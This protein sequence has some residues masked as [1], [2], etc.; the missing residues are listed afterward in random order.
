MNYKKPQDEEIALGND[1]LAILQDDNVV[2]GD[3]ELAEIETHLKKLYAA[4]LIELYSGLSIRVEFERFVKRPLYVAAL[5]FCKG[6]KEKVAKLLGISTVKL[7]N[8]L[9]I[10]YGSSCISKFAITE[11]DNRLRILY[12][13]YLDQVLTD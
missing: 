9:T 11:S 6:N 3:D 5:Y 12:E 7:R 8:K 2:I 10:F 4:R 1:E 13:N